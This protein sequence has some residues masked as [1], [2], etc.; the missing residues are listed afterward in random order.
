MSMQMLDDF[1]C[2]GS[3]GSADDPVELSARHPLTARRVQRIANDLGV[4]ILY[5]ESG[6]G[7][8]WTS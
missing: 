8:S 5:G 3:L 4:A 1:E 7:N 2:F 6:G